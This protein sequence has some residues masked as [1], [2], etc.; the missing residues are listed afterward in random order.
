MPAMALVRIVW[1]PQVGVLDVDD[2][3]GRCSVGQDEVGGLGG[4][5]VVER[6]VGGL[7]AHRV[8]RAGK[9]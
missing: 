1:E 7:P 9:R 3:Q 8:L 6:A 2:E 5:P 4:V